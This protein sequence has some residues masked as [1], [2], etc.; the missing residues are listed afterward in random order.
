VLFRSQTKGYW[1][2]NP[3]ET[4]DLGF[5]GYYQ[6]GTLAL[7]A[8]GGGI[9]E[10]Q[11]TLR[12]GDTKINLG[13]GGNQDKLLSDGQHYWRIEYK[14][15]KPFREFDPATGEGGRWSLPKFFEEFSTEQKPIY[16]QLSHLLHRFRR[17]LS[18]HRWAQRMDSSDIVPGAL[19]KKIF[20]G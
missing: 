8:P 9:T 10:G 11:S 4:Q 17:A 6:I 1:S 19:E 20:T 2:N 14:D 5:V 7:P 18:R 16:W 13:H 12:V 15:G 3:H